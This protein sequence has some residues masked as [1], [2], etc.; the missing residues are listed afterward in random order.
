MP[1]DKKEEGFL[2]K[3]LWLVGG[4]LAFVGGFI[5]MAEHGG[6]RGVISARSISPHVLLVWLPGMALLGIAWLLKN[7]RSR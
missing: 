2:E 7:A 1:D 6:A 4:I 5:H 3:T